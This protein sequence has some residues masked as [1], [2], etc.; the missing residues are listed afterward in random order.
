M[1]AQVLEH[2]GPKVASVHVHIEKGHPPNC[3][4]KGPFPIVT[5]N[6]LFLQ[7]AAK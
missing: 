1:A 5:S 2:S 6:P 4:T 7:R 3:M